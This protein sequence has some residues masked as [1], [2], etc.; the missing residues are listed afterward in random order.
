MAVL[1]LGPQAAGVRG[2]EREA[3]LDGSLEV[4]G[5]QGRA[6]T[7]GKVPNNRGKNLTLIASMSLSG[8]E[9][10]GASREPRTR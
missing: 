1:S 2:G 7:Y 4:W 10:R 8:M 3:Y 6:S 9:S 5:S